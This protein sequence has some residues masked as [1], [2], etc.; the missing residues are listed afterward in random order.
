[1]EDLVRPPVPEQLLRISSLAKLE[2]PALA[3]ARVVENS[4]PAPIEKSFRI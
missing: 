3:L 2:P 1:M 4:L